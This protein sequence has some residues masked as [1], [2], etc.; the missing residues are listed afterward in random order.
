MRT[1]VTR[2]T[3]VY[4]ETLAHICIIVR[5]FLTFPPS[6]PLYTQD[7][8]F[9]PDIFELFP[10]LTLRLPPSLQR[11]FPSFAALPPSALVDSF[12][13]IAEQVAVDHP[14]IGVHVWD[15]GEALNRGLTIDRLHPTVQGHIAVGEALAGL[16][17][18]LMS[19]L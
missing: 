4:Q 1:F 10:I 3:D 16:L 13:Q 9:F 17:R 19:S 15:P 14:S 11:P 12:A 6:C 18:P 5:S 8:A 2:L 7:A